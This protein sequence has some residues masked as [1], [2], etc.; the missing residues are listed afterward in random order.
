M[1]ATKL[2]G[3]NY[4]VYILIS[5]NFENNIFYLH[6]LYEFEPYFKLVYPANLHI[7]DKLRQTLQNLRNK[8]LVKFIG[9]GVYQLEDLNRVSSC[10]DKYGEEVVYLLSNSSIPE[11]VKIGRSSSINRRMK[12]LYNTSVPLPFRLEDRLVVHSVGQSQVLEKTIHSMIDTINPDARKNT[13]ANKRE[14]F[15]LSVDQG[16]MIFQLVT[17]IAK[18]DIERNKSLSL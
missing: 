1:D 18:I 6:E 7:K 2:K 15:K 13:E 14:F 8:R 3:W 17:R 5:N 16:K 12:E 4:I 10:D 9:K 11:W